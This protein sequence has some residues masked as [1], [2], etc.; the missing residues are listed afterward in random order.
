MGVITTLLNHQAASSHPA[1]NK[2]VAGQH[3]AVMSLGGAVDAGQLSGYFLRKATARAVA[4]I[5]HQSVQVVLHPR[6]SPQR[7]NRVINM[8]KLL[9]RVAKQARRMQNRYSLSIDHQDATFCR[10]L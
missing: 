7:F 9:F 3:P 6:V 8:G 4:V 2:L 5:H 1:C 10:S